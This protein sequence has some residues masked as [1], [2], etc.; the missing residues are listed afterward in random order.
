MRIIGAVPAGTG[1][2]VL[3]AE[4]AKALPDYELRSYSPWLELLPPLMRRVCA[5]PRPDVVHAT[6]EYG[7]WLRRPDARLVATAHNYVS[8]RAI[9]PYV[10]S[11]QYLHYRTDL[12]WSARRTVEQADAIVAVSH[13][14]AQMLRD[15]FGVS[16]P[17]QVIYN[18]VDTARFAPAS[19]SRRS[20]PFRVLFCGN[21]RCRKRP[22][23]L[24]PL[25]RALGPEFE[26]HY[27]QG[28]RRSSVSL[29]AGR[30]AARM[31]CVGSVAHSDM[32][33]L[34]RQVDLLFMPS[35][36][37]GFGLCVAE[38]MA[39]GLPV[40]AADAGAL[41]E[42]VVEGQGGHLCA[43]DD[44]SAFATAIR[45]ISDDRARAS[46]M[47]AFNRARAEE[48]FG[49]VAMARQYQS[50]FQAVLDKADAG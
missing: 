7:C 36:R 32:P 39:C 13:F 48:R 25:A 4:L 18:G 46:R 29:E 5:G 42:L 37:E 12:A 47:G 35:A 2:T 30:E 26:I 22:A 38:A 50:L 34:Y 6:L 27:T 41:P 33:T 1:A 31:V 17:V 14:V 9:R 19:P 20:G 44:V 24:A 40:V 11:L 28:L 3:H 10:S 45:N 8:D 21:H 49:A 16:R 23:L 43:I 15:D